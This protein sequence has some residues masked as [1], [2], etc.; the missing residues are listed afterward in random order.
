[1][2]Q[3]ICMIYVYHICII[4]FWMSS[5]LGIKE[6]ELQNSFFCYLPNFYVYSLLCTRKP[7]LPNLCLQE[8][9]LGK[10]DKHHHDGMLG[11]YYILESLDSMFVVVVV[12]VL[13]LTC[14]LSI[15]KQYIEK[16]YLHSNRLWVLQYRQ[17]FN[18]PIFCGVR[19]RGIAPARH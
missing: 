12:E 15:S 14:L 17:P 2:K 8:R 19:N 10:S 18:R 13:L 11:T 16:F 1:M 7:K 3:C 5:F 6:Q 4:I 9:G